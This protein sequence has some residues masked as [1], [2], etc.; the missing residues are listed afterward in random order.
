MNKYE[1]ARS[2]RRMLCPPADVHFYSTHATGA[3]LIIRKITLLLVQVCCYSKGPLLYYNTTPSCTTQEQCH[4]QE[5]AQQYLPPAPQ[6]QPASGPASQT[7]SKTIHH[8]R[9]STSQSASESVNQPASESANKPTSQ[10][11]SQSTSQLANQ[12]TSLPAT[13]TTLICSF[14]LEEKSVRARA[15]SSEGNKQQNRF[16]Q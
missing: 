10:S 15:R 12:L 4:M 14:E 6:H 13:Y 7:P 1:T 2:Q 11:A 9:K 8:A 3:H 5:Q 16:F